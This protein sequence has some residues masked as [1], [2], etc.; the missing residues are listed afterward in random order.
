MLQA[1]R[2]RV[3]FPMRLLDFSID[4]ILPAALWPWRSAQ[5]L[6]EM[7]TRDLPGGKGRLV[8]KA[9]DLAVICDPIV[10]K[11]WEPR[12]LTTL[13]AST[14]TACY[15]DSF[16]CFLFFFILFLCCWTKYDAGSEFDL[17]MSW[18]ESKGDVKGL[19]KM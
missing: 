12:H 14:A 8:H 7:S 2:L 19:M 10:Y 6:T 13:W 3:Q 4:L 1:G 11:I 17:S 15:S 16:T 5:P 9:D 18:V